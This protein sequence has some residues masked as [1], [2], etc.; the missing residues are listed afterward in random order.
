MD[1][2][3]YEH[4]KEEE[5]QEEDT[6]YENND[7]VVLK[8]IP[9]GFEEHQ[10]RS[11]FS[12]ICTVKDIRLI[13]NPKT[14]KFRG[15][16]FVRIE[17]PDYVDVFIGELNNYPLGKKILKCQ[18]CLATNKRIFKTKKINKIDINP[19]LAKQIHNNRLLSK[20]KDE[21][22]KP[23]SQQKYDELMEKRDELEKQRMQKIKEKGINYQ[24]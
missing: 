6:I 24:F 2:E 11:F 12:Q 17:D 18:K 16:A 3:N 22:S 4:V 8:H 15:V 7:V 5:K 9:R 23:L 1:S 19:E 10:L 14:K 20:F 21:S 13:R